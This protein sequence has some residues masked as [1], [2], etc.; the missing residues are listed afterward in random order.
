MVVIIVLK[1]MSMFG[2]KRRITITKSFIISLCFICLLMVIFSFGADYVVAYD[3]N[4]SLDEM[5]LDLGSEDK[6]EN[7]QNVE[8]LQAADNSKATKTFSDIQGMIRESNEGD[9]IN[10]DGYYVAQSKD[11]QIKVDKRLTITSTNGAI[12]DSK[13]LTPMFLFENG[14]KGSLLSNIQFTNGNGQYGGAVIINHCNGVTIRNCVFEDNRAEYRGAAIY[15]Y[16][17]NVM[18]DGCSFKNNNAGEIAGALYAE[19]TGA[20]KSNL[21]IL[22]CNFTNNSAV[23]SGGAVT[24][25]NNGSKVVDCIFDS[26]HVINKKQA[27]GGAIQIGLDTHVSYGDVYNCI[28]SNNYAITLLSNYE[29]H[30]GAGCVRNGTSFFNCTFINNSADYGGAVTFHANGTMM[31]CTFLNNSANMYGGALAIKLL[32]NTMNLNVSNCVFKYNDA[33]YGGAIKLSGMDIRIEDTIFEENHAS[34]NGAAVNIEAVNVNV[35][36]ARFHGNVA[37]KDGGAI[38][39]ISENTHVS[40][41]TFLSNS[42]IPDKDKLDDG[43][44]GAIYINSTQAIV[45]NNIFKYNKARNGSAIYY[46]E[47][48][49]NL[50]FTNNTLFENQ[51]WVYALPI[52]AEDIYYGDFEKITSIIHGGNNIADYDNL[53]V[54][55]A[56]Y[57]A[58]PNRYIE[59]NGETPVSGATMSGELYQDDREYNIEILLSVEHEDGTLVYNSTLNSNYL[60]EVSATLDNLKPGKYYVT[61]RHSEDT[62]YKAIV[63]QTSFRVIPKVDVSVKKSTD[64]MAFNYD[65][66]VVWTLNITN[67]GPNDASG[68]YLID[69][70]P[71]GLI[72]LE[73]IGNYDEKTGRLDVGFVNVGETVT[74]SMRT[75]INRTGEITNRVNV[76]SNEADIDLS[77]NFD[78]RSILVNPASDLEVKK[79]VDKPNPNYQDYVNWTITVVNN[80]PDIAQEVVIRDLL[81][82]GLVLIDAS[83]NFDEDN[84]VWNIETLN[85]NQKVVLNIISLVNSTGL[86]QNNVSAKSRTFDYDLTNNNDSEVIAVNPSCD[87]AI[88]KSANASEFNYGDLIRWTLNVVNNG[89]SN[90]TGVNVTEKLPDG[91]VPINLTGDILVI[92]DLGVGESIS[93][94]ILCRANKTGNFTN[95]ASVKGNEHDHNLSNNEAIGQVIVKPAT[96]LGVVKLVSNDEANYGDYVNWTVHVYNNGPDIAHEVIVKDLFTDSLIWVNDSS[97][98]S[99]NRSSGEWNVGTLNVGEIRTLVIKSIVNSTGLV[100]NEVSVSGWEFDYDLT[101]NQDLEVVMVNESADLSIVKSVNCTAVNY[102]ELVKWTLT[103]SNMG[104]SNATAVYVTDVL[105][106]GLELV[107]YTTTKGIYDEGKWKICCMSNGDV[108]TLEIICR[109]AKTGDFINVASIHGDEYDPNPANNED[110]ESISVPESADVEVTKDVNNTDLLFG[111]WVMWK[112]SIRNNGPDDA[113]N[114]MVSDE[115][116]SGLRF[117]DYNATKGS[118]DGNVWD[119]GTLGIGECQY[120]NIICEVIKLDEITNSVEANC[121]EYDWNKSNNFDEATI[122]AEPICDLAI[123]KLSNVD[124]ANYGDLI[125]WKLI[126]SNNG[127]NNATGV[128]VEDILPYGLVLIDCD[129]DYDGIHWEVGDLASGQTRELEITCKVDST[130]EIINYANVYGN[131][132]DS[133]L[134]NNNDSASIFINPASDLAITKKASKSS[135]AVGD[136]IEYAIEVVNNGPDKA[137]NVRVTEIL[138]DLLVLKS[139]KVSMGN[140]DMLN[141]LWTIDSLEVG[142]KAILHIQALAMGE[143]II[144]NDV[145]VTGDNFDYDLNNNFDSVLVNVSS[146]NKSIKINNLKDN[147]GYYHMIDKYNPSILQKYPTADPII[148]L[149]IVSFFSIIFGSI[150]IS[151]KR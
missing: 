49:K 8:V 16:A 70:L 40:N 118:F 67:N 124:N 13:N 15:M 84:G 87:L 142:Q 91:L 78:E 83:S 120:L 27:Y 57:N 85:V 107:N 144:R 68:V 82:K 47:F 98:G 36:N 56:I 25:L 139:F 86:I 126:V 74:V 20:V 62:Y 33:P 24:A 111:E 135:Y 109:I 112:I 45:E 30:G 61:A 42:A 149:M 88:S 90:A 123:V 18:V 99:Y 37:E 63:N 69:I 103:A 145:S 76:T 102:K 14:A 41:S 3:S 121:S 1:E 106:D 53:A 151:K 115:L 148:I 38:F 65:D 44:G 93:I 108:E 12:L 28:F 71:E 131:E 97:K 146:P 39:I 141:Q 96:D 51:A 150:N 100:E 34:I 105:P 117:V 136:I 64:S 26:N 46:D 6:L 116:P 29:S 9:T 35:N 31:N 52:F 125:R 23:V 10:L 72:L 81:P 43:L 143:G 21:R 60:G 55:N 94:D 137:T 19:Y 32:H 54:S 50:K 95:F 79:D 5:E 73:D 59:V 77:N 66:I 122:N 11:D 114:V 128:V 138:D 113:T 22:N 127:P 119:V 104:P 7:S 4:E 75:L 89:P 134:T 132:Y 110:N 17:D 140:F 133:N 129:G 101:N 130:G 147:Q 80:G 2:N 58:A 92:G 48:G